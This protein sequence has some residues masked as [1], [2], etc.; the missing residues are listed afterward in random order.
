[1]KML[2]L[3]SVDEDKL[4]ECDTDFHTEMGW[5]AESGIHTLDA[6]TV[7]DSITEISSMSKQ[8]FMASI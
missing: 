1:M 6:V 8:K 4:K 3:L 2:V 5:V 7:S